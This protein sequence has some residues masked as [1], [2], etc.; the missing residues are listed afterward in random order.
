MF[1]FKLCSDN[2]KEWSWAQGGHFLPSI[3]YQPLEF[4]GIIVENSILTW[5][6]CWRY[7]IEDDLV[8]A[9]LSFLHL[10]FS[11]RKVGVGKGLGLGRIME[12]T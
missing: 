2:G 1:V 9:R 10:W 6:S 7:A 4:A 3:L 11:L 12:Y 8:I 5:L